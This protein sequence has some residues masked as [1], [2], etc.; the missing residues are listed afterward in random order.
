MTRY[1]YERRIPMNKLEI[2]IDYFSVTFP[3][4]I[5]AI[6]FTQF[7]VHKTVETIAT[8]LNVQNFEIKKANLPHFT[9]HGLRHTDITLQITAG[10]PLVIV[11]GRA[12]H[13]R[14]STTT[15]VYSHFI[16]SSDN[17]AASTLDNLFQT[18][19]VEEVNKKLEEFRKIKQEMRQIGFE[20]IKDYMEILEFKQVKQHL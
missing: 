16:Q 1:L 19:P 15:D 12:G 18:E 8:Y 6:E 20:T 11:S 2:K 4:D 5:S 17:V 13:S 14:T 7:K 3:L 9:I 10:V